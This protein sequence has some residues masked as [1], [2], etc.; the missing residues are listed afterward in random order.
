LTVHGNYNNGIASKDDLKITGGNIEIHSADDGL[1]GRDMVAVKE[2]T[3]SIEAGG[4]GIKSTNDTDTTKGFIAIEGGSFDIKSGTDGIQAETSL[5]INNGT[6]DISSGGGSAN[7]IVK[8]NDR[9]PG[10]GGNTTANSNETE[11]KSTKGMKSA[12]ILIGGGNFNI[13]SADDSLHSNNSIAIAGGDITITSGDDGIHA[14]SSIA[15]GNGK[16]NITKS[17]EGIEAAVITVADGNIHVIS[18]DDGINAGGGADGSSVNG[19][20]GQNNFADTGTNKLNINGGYIVVNSMGDGLDSNGSIYMTNGTVIVSGPTENNNGA[21]DY[22]GTFE[23]TGGFLV[24]AGSSGMAQATSDS[25]T[26]YSIIMNYPNTQAAGTVVHLEDSKGNTIA[27]FA[28]AKEYQAVVISSPELKKG[29]SYTLFSGGTSTAS[30]TDGLYAD[31]E[32]KGGTKV[33]DF[34]VSSSVTWLDETGVTTAKSAGPGQ[35]FGGGNRSPRIK[36]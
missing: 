36:P 27:T 9:G 26:Q 33:V 13:D 28:P 4:D 15:I 16:I 5:L 3:I 21:L 32:Y 1:M 22:N 35:G 11:E 19:R 2:G 12:D 17:Y 23:M 20:P 29:T 31:G 30:Q 24:A 14:D 18:S 8:T 34:T 10:P 7:A 25:S 6:F